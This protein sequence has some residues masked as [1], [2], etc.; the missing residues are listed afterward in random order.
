MDVQSLLRSYVPSDSREQA[1]QLRMLE[2]AEKGGESC[3]RHH[4]VPG[5]FT[6]S[7]FVFSPDLEQV[8]L[9]FHP[10]FQRW[11][12]PGGHIEGEDAD[13]WAAARREV[14]EELGITD[15]QPLGEGL[16]DIDIHDIPARKDEPIHQHFDLRVA[17]IASVQALT[18]EH[19]A[20]WV[21]FSDAR[22]L[23]S[24]DSVQ[25]GLLKRPSLPGGAAG[26]R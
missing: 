5:H 1:F 21:S 7:A 8:A 11:L 22:K 9:I 26:R 24:D 17:F 15:L 4:Y 20:R 6:A 23:E 13:A 12:Q 3:F 16:W 14:Q 2:L 25:R 10:K 18:G 19:E